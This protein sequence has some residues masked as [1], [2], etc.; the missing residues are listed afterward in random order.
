MCLVMKAR[1]KL[2]KIN[3]E[4]NA[5][6]DLLLKNNLCEVGMTE[7]SLPFSLLAKTINL[8]GVKNA[9]PVWT[10]TLN[11]VMQV[12]GLSTAAKLSSHS[13][14]LIKSKVDFCCLT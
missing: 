10:D 9:T 3:T 14:F 13:L 6:H 5:R 4:L 2:K 1:N 12:F 11:S 7:E 8:L